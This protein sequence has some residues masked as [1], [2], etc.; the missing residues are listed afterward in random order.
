MR[1]FDEFWKEYPR[2]R[3]KGQAQKA[4]IKLKVDEQLLAEILSGLKRAKT[5]DFNKREPEHIPYP[6]TWLNAS[7]WNDEYGGKISGGYQAKEF[8]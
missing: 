2:K 3:S 7:G 5:L 8:F 6:A 4:W 1:F